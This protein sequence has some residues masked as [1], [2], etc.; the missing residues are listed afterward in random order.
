MISITVTGLD[1]A[2]IGIRRVAN[3]EADQLLLILGN[4]I[5]TQ[6]I[7]HFQEEAG[8]TGAWAGWRPSTAAQRGS[9]Q[10][11]SDTGRLR[12][13]ISS[14]IGANQVEVG[15]NLFYGKFHQR[16][17]R[18]MVARPFVGLSGRDSSELE[19]TLNAYFAR[20]IG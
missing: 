4:L 8:P 12:G 9:G 14:I 6:T 15:T 20:L 10:I 1:R 7:R 17:T 5:R 2:T 11:L 18:K 16:G 3:F 19:M 13:S